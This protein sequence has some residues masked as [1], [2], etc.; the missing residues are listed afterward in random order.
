MD[1]AR[2]GA[3]YFISAVSSKQMVFHVDGCL[4]SNVSA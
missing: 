4:N 1:R 3:V 2:K